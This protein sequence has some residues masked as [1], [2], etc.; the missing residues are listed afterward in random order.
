MKKYL[1][2]LII[3]ALLAA[4]VPATA[5]ASTS[6]VLWTKLMVG[7]EF[8][9]EVNVWHDD[10]NLYVNYKVYTHWGGIACLRPIYMLP[11][12]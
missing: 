11:P 9:G 5:S 1:Y 3:V 8:L 12:R 2:L 4:L 7:K 6:P 10:D